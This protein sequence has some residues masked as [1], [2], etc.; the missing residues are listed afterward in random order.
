MCGRY[1]HLLTWSQVVTLYQLTSGLEAP[2][3]FRP[4]YNI[5]PTQM[6]PVVRMK[7]GQ[8]ELAM[9]RWGVIPAWAKDRSIGNKM[10]NARAEGVAEKPAFGSALR[11]RRC[12]V[13]SGGFYEW[14]KGAGKEKQPFWI[15]M[16]DGG[17]F[18]MAGLWERWRDRERGEAIE[19]FTII[20]TVANALVAPIHDRMPV[21]V[22]P[23]NFDAWLTAAEP[24]MGLL[25]PYAAA[26]MEA[27]PVSR[28]VNRPAQDEPSLIEPLTGV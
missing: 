17:E 15:G 5:A 4:R 9:L 28:A 19:S 25:R 6:A 2:A 24:P 26:A 14:Q 20:T 23:A 18:A 13:L 12:L 21:L 10:I 8:R 16:K 11:A 3:E 27:Y 7:N 22:D 1:T